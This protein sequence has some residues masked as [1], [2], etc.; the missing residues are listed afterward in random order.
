MRS[1]RKLALIA[2]AAIN[3]L[4]L[5]LSLAHAAVAFD[6][7]ATLTTTT[8]D[9]SFD[10]VPVGTVRAVVVYVVVDGVNVGITAVTADGAAL[11][12]TAD[13]PTTKLTGEAGSSHCFFLG[14]SIPAGTLTIAIDT[15][16]G[17]EVICAVAVTLTADQDTSV[18]DTASFTSDNDSNPSVTLGL[19]GISSFCMLGALSGQNNPAS[20]TPLTNW[21]SRLENDFG[22]SNGVVYTYDTVD[23]TDVAAGYTAANDDII[24][25]AVAIRENAAAG[26]NAAQI[27]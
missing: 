18:V 24:L 15:T 6:N 17:T 22:V 5:N 27:F 14:S 2:T 20:V 13:S 23:T 11:T 3:I 26:G 1:L 7:A 19:G 4:C 8:G 9:G 25:H 16:L 12:E 21:T 10:I